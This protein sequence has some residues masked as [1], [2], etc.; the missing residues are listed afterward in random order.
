MQI[1]NID[2]F[3]LSMGEGE[4]SFPIDRAYVG[5]KIKDIFVFDARYIAY[6]PQGGG[7]LYQYA[8]ESIFIDLFDKHQHQIFRSVPFSV[9]DPE[10]IQR[11]QIDTE[12]DFTLCKFRSVSRYV[13]NSYT[14]W[15]FFGVCVVYEDR[16]PFISTFGNCR[17]TLSLTIA[18]G[19]TLNLR[20]LLAEFRAP[21]KVRR[22]LIQYPAILTSDYS[23][24][25]SEIYITL[26]TKNGRV[27]ENIPL[28]FLSDNSKM[29]K[30][31]D[32]SDFDEEKCFITNGGWSYTNV[33][34]IIEYDEQ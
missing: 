7:L 15:N 13:K 27:F 12:L 33:N 11:L 23:V 24:D 26:R 30:F 2:F 29:N 18:N 34:I 17:R 32:L 3:L 31:L 10:N 21:K 25:K 19:E 14:T 28:S 9:F 8:S 22:I 20:S 1:Q 16:E 5:K 6:P 4:V